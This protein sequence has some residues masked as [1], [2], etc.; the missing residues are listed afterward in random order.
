MACKYNGHERKIRA[1][2]G[3]RQ[4]TRDN[5]R[6]PREQPVQIEARAVQGK[7]AGDRF[8]VWRFRSR[9]SIFLNI[10]KNP[11]DLPYHFIFSC[12]SQ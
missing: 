6:T 9:S 10:K 8:S 1:G 2:R 3:D 11:A 7:Q 4:L 12:T 5:F